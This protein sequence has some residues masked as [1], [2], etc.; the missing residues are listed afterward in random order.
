M[1]TLDLEV[2]HA[3]E[4]PEHANMTSDYTIEDELY[5]GMQFND[6]EA[7]VQAIKNYNIFKSVDY[8]VCES[9]SMTFYCKY[10]YYGMK[11]NWF[12]RV[13]FKKKKN[14][15]STMAHTFVLL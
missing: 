14:S 11:C 13:D 5:V 10:K 9:K 1:R 6:R 12:V 4:F 8:N 3:H 2:M 15:E 7:V